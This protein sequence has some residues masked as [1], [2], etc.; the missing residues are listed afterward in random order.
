MRRDINLSG[1]PCW[2]LI[3]LW[4]LS[5]AQYSYRYILQVNDARTT[6]YYESTPTAPSA[7]KYVLFLIFAVYGIA[8]LFRRPVRFSARYRRPEQLTACGIL[9]VGAVLLIRAVLLPGDFSDTCLCAMQLL[10]WVASILLV[11][12]IVTRKHDAVR[13]LAVFE[14]I[15]FWLTFTFWLTTVSLAIAG[16]RYPALS[17]PGVL[18]RFGGILDDPNGYACLCLLLMMLAL[19][20]RRRRWILR[21]ILYAVMTAGTLSLTG[22]VTALISCFCLAV[23]RIYRTKQAAARWLLIGCVICGLAL[24]AVALLPSMYNLNQAM[25]V[26]NEVYSAKG[27]SATTH[28]LDLL[29]TDATLQESSLVGVLFGNGGFSEN[30]YWRILANLGVIGLLTIIALLT[31]WCYLGWGVQER[32]RRTFTAWNVGV[33]IGSNGIAYL[34]TFP[35]GLIFWSALALVLYCRRSTPVP[36]FSPRQQLSRTRA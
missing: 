20:T 21:S 4:I 30:F 12:L 8:R 7:I 17:Y 6:S 27:S 9:I 31:V 5:I 36:S 18:L 16:I 15:A 24:T 32:W 11:P 10:P 22:Y 3:W 28:I 34:L 23:F 33:L 19:G 35:L 1:Q 2:A 25:Q 13:T 26:F 29:P 14:Q